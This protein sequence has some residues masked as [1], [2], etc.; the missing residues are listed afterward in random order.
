[1]ALTR[2]AS[3]SYFTPMPFRNNYWNFLLKPHVNLIL[4][5]CPLEITTGEIPV[6]ISKGHW[7][8]IRFTCGFNKKFQ[9]LFLKGTGVK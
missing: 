8:K 2:N 6:V 9:L 3:K 7:C 1:V 5:Q 4:H